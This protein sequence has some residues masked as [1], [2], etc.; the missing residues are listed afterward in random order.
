MYRLDLLSGNRRNI[1]WAS[2]AARVAMRAAYCREVHIAEPAYR[3]IRTRAR[4]RSRCA[5]R[6]W[7]RS[8]RA[9]SQCAISQC[10]PS[11]PPPRRRIDSPSIRR[12]R[13]SRTSQRAGAGAD[14]CPRLHANLATSRSPHITPVGTTVQMVAS[15][16]STNGRKL[17]WWR[18]SVVDT[19][20]TSS[21]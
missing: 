16:G 1:P 10:S 20:Q 3:G 2:S 21:A 14:P 13:P 4:P 9:R 8:S 17:Q 12:A 6:A 15:G 11:P 5:V 18:S 7:A 19:M